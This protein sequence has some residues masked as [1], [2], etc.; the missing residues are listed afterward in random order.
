MVN[1]SNKKL[2]AVSGGV[3]S[4]YLLNEFKNED[5]IVAHVNYNIRE[6]V[7]IDL[8]I[9]IDFCDKNNIKLETLS[10]KEEYS[11]NFHE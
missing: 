7:D 6:D 2:I 10:L 1:R 3:D 5:I 9:I 4:M 8:K 11:G